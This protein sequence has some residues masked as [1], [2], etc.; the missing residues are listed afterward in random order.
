[1]TEKSRKCFTNYQ[2]AESFLLEKMKDEN[3]VVYAWPE[4]DQYIV[5]WW[6]YKSIIR[7][8]V[9]E[10]DEVWITETGEPILVQDMTEDQ[11]KDAVRAILRED[12]KL[13]EDMN[14]AL[15]DLVEN[16][17]GSLQDEYGIS[18]EAVVLDQSSIEKKID[19]LF[20]DDIQSNRRGNW[21]H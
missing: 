7:D 17:V 10:K 12:R 2:D 16:I 14:R 6:L 1:M 11:A 19:S 8:G 15:G 4:N 20:P 5:E 21:L 9:E 13:S 18:A 3:Y